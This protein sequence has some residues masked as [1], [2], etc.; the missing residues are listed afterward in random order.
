[1][2]VRSEA[3]LA[4]PDRPRFCPLNLSSFW[5]IHT[6]YY[7]IQMVSST[8][9]HLYFVF[10]IFRGPHFR[11]QHS[12]PGATLGSYRGGPSVVRVERSYPHAED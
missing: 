4:Y 1:M 10:C 9:F 8:L 5:R 6:L 12:F 2:Y 11:S 7:S 3:A